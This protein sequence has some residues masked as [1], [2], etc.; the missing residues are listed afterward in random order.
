MAGAI[1]VALRRKACC[2]PIRD[3]LKAVIPSEFA[4]NILLAQ[5]KVPRIAWKY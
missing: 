2:A 3:D 4:G 1:F 5:V